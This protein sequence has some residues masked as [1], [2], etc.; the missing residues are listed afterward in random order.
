MLL[1]VPD[2]E[3]E[4]DNDNEK[5][6]SDDNDYGDRLFSSD[7]DDSE[8]DGKGDVTKPRSQSSFGRIVLIVIVFAIV[9]VMMGSAA[10]LTFQA[11]VEEPSTPTLVRT[12]PPTDS[13]SELTVTDE[14][15]TSTEE[16]TPLADQTDSD[17]SAPVTDATDTDENSTSLLGLLGE[18]LPTNPP[19]TAVPPTDVPTLSAGTV[20]ALTAAPPAD[21]FDSATDQPVDATTVPQPTATTL[22][23]GDEC[24]PP[25]DWVPY[26]V[27]PGDTLSLIAGRA[28]ISVEE[29]GRGNCFTNFQFIVVGESI[30]VP[31]DL[32]YVPPTP[33]PPQPLSTQPVREYGLS[34]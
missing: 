26:E 16:P 14:A 34:N 27:G 29:L 6:S 15:T 12:L 22:V 21:L 32:E 19:P 5:L 4:K 25:S 9:V 31:T 30:L 10:F 8:P 17:E 28:G 24:T 3:P 1:L 2:S 11:S 33:I 18:V 20:A 13:E 7:R 23:S